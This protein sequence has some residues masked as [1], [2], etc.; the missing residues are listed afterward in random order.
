[1][2]GGVFLKHV[3]CARL[4]AIIV[5]AQI[6]LQNAR[7]AVF[8]SIFVCAPFFFLSISVRAQ[9]QL[10]NLWGAVSVFN[11]GAQIKIRNFQGV[12]CF[13]IFG[14]FLFFRQRALH[15]FVF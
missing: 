6:Q 2:G 13:S 4:F 15:F 11:L 3:V 8:L 1:M 14:V 9:I 12:V 5:R 7:G 10:Q